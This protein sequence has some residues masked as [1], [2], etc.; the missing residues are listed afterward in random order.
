MCSCPDRR[1]AVI[2]PEKKQGQ[3]NEKNPSET[4]RD[5]LLR[6]DSHTTEEEKILPIS[7]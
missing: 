4:K 6:P 1:E 7:D 3:S 2:I 5:K